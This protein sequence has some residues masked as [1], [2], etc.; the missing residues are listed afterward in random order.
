MALFIILL[1]FNDATCEL[2]SFPK[3]NISELNAP[4]SAL[5]QG[6]VD[7]LPTAECKSDADIGRFV[8]DSNICV[9]PTDEVYSCTVSQFFISPSRII[10][11]RVDF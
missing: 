1:R 9:S 5:Q 6:K 10:M 3:F 4:N 7:M 8:T 11:N 2:E